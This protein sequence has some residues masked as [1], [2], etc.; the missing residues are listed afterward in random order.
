MHH[1]L[2]QQGQSKAFST[3]HGHKQY[4]L[5]AT[6]AGGL[7]ALGRETLQWR[8]CFTLSVSLRVGRGD[9]RLQG[10]GVTGGEHQWV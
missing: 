5:T 1:H 9:L 2:C 8:L 6:S 10:F 3:V 7:G 4:R